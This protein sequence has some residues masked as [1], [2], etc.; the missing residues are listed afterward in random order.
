MRTGRRR[1]T[2]RLPKLIPLSESPPERYQVWQFIVDYEDLY[3]GILGFSEVSMS[4]FRLVLEVLG[5]T[6]T[7]VR[8]LH[9]AII[10][11]IDESAVC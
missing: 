9:A 1:E 3:H 2:W 8:Q 6:N 4:R 11:N 7:A 10:R 5:C